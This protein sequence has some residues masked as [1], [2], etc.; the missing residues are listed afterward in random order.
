[1]VL[2]EKLYLPNLL[3][4]LGDLCVSQVLLVSLS[5]PLIVFVCICSRV[6]VCVRFV[7]VCLPSQT[8]L[9]E[10][11]DHFIQLYIPGACCLSVGGSRHF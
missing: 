1:M 11:K 3:K 8:E 4:T 10:G 6:C 9:F 2:S 5:L 7:C